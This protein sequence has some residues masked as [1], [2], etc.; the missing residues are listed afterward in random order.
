MNLETYGSLSSIAGLILGVITLWLSYRPGKLTNEEKTRRIYG[1][2]FVAWILLSFSIW[3]YYKCSDDTVQ[4]QAKRLNLANIATISTS[5]ETL[6]YN[7]IN[8]TSN[9][10]VNWDFI[11]SALNGI[12]RELVDLANRSKS[13]MSALR[14]LTEKDQNILI[15]SEVSDEYQSVLTLS[16]EILTFSNKINSEN[17]NE[18]LTEFYASHPRWIEELEEF[19]TWMRTFNSR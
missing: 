6:K 3:T 1:L 19:E 9:D 12:A 8:S 17:G 4:T 11:K 18:H 10:P 7:L 16:N 13:T 2:S 14:P 15:I 5:V